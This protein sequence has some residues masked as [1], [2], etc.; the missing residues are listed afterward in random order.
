MG[1]TP[2]WND[3]EI[4]QQRSRELERA[5]PAKRKARKTRQESQGSGAA[6]KVPAPRQDAERNSSAN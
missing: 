6:Q 1:K 5:L 3:P 2:Y 4:A